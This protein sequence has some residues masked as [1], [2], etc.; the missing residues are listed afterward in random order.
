MEPAAGQ[1][2]LW[3]AVGFSVFFIC[4]TGMYGIGLMDFWRKYLAAICLVFLV[5]HDIS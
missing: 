2:G 5:Y 3:P 1:L 4:E